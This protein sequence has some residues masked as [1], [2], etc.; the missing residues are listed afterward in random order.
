[1][2]RKK[3]RTEFQSFRSSMS[4]VSPIEC[5]PWW[6]RNRIKPEEKKEKLNVKEA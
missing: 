6:E 5:R 2:S 1:M 4:K 3:S